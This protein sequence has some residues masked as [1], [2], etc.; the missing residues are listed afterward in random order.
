[1]TP[2]AFGGLFGRLHTGDPCCGGLRRG[3]VLCPAFGHEGLWAAGSWRRLAEA[4][5]AAGLVC[6]AIDYAGLGD[7]LGDPDDPGRVAAWGAS[8][9]AAVAY[10]RSEIGVESVGLAGLR[11]GGL[12][13][14]DVAAEVGAESLALLAPF[15]TGRGFVR[16]MQ[17][18]GRILGRLPDGR[19][20]PQDAPG[21]LNLAGFPF[22][23][24][25]LADLRALDLR[26]PKAPPAPRAL[27]AAP[28]PGGEAAALADALAGAGTAVTRTGFPGFPEMVSNPIE[29]APPLA[30]FAQVAAFL[31]QG[32]GTAPAPIPRQPSA[33]LTGADFTETAQSF[34]P[35]GTLSGILCR[36]SGPARTGDL[37]LVLVNAGLNPRSG[38]ARG[39]TTLAR[40]LAAQGTASLRFD[41]AGIGDSAERSGAGLPLF[42]PASVREVSAALDLLEGAGF[43]RM[44]VVGGCSG[45]YLALH[46]ALADRRVAGLVLVNMPRFF[47]EPDA[48]IAAALRDPYR[49]A[50]GYLGIARNAGAWRRVLEGEVDVAGILRRLAGRALKQGWGALRERARGTESVRGRATR[51]M[52]ALAARGVR[53]R[54]VY[55]VA[56]SGLSECERLFGPGGQRLAARHGC[57]LHLLADT[58]HDLTPRP[59][60]EA[61]FAQVEELV[62]A[63]EVGAASSAAPRPRRVRP[64]PGGRKRDGARIARHFP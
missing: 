56:D 25:T 44:A 52:A 61:M 36:P 33:R 41:L 49:A 64:D 42:D 24:E 47:W 30:L 5:A 20:A 63:L 2:V 32:A 15:A 8:V 60:R 59:A 46:A 11:F 13:A 12:M 22:T 16:E 9:R 23:P 40:R 54:L 19:P 34:G 37:A 4:V 43:R 35:E 57:A 1:M 28:P 51:A 39:G 14:L 31:A 17:A 38:W 26:S 53:T 29:A 27:V 48:D 10:L 45:A 3:V 6:L 55:S 18:Q 58:D 62:R 7:S 21:T 50:S